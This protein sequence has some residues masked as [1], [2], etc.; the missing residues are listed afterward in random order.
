MYNFTKKKNKDTLTYGSLYLKKLFKHLSGFGLVLLM[1]VNMVNAQGSFA[2]CI[3][4]ESTEWSLPVMTLHPSYELRHDLFVDPMDDIF[5]QGKDF[6]EWGAPSPVP[7]FSSWTN[8]PMQDKSDLMNGAAVIFDNIVGTPADCSPAFGDYMDGHTYLFFAGDRLSNNGT[9]YI[10]FWFLIDGSKAIDDGSDQYFSPNHYT[11]FGELRDPSDP[12]KGTWG[13]DDCVGDLLLL[14]NFDSGGRNA[15]VTVYKWVGQGNGTVGGNKQSL[16]PFYPIGINA[17]VGK[18]N[19][20]FVAVPPNFKVPDDQLMVD[21]TDGV[22]GDDDGIDNPVKV[23]DY[24]EFYEGV[25]DLTPIFQLEG[26]EKIICS[27]TWMLETRSSDELT[28]DSKDFIGG[29]FNL[30]PSIRASGETV[31]TGATGTLTAELYRPD[32]PDTPQ[33]EE[34][35]LPN[36]GYTFHWYTAADWND[37]NDANNNDIGDGTNQLDVTDG[38][39][40]YV[41]ATSDEECD[42]N[43]SGLASLSFYPDPMV[44]ANNDGPYCLGDMISLTATFTAGGSSTSAMSWSWTGPDG[45]TSNMEDPTAFAA[46]AA[47]AGEYTVEVTDNNGCKNTAKTTVVVNPDPMVSANNDGPYCLGDMISLTATFTAGGSS[48]SAMSWSWTG[49][50]GFT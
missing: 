26:N 37:G 44:S 36:T 21:L 9:G 20:G 40:Y 31:C 33:N 3:D 18:N 4:G 7:E 50:D 24:N 19:D 15:L 11:N 8:S 12:S 14:A 43:G 45:F 38:L 34:M 42:A 1:S 48:T 17:Q 46:T 23:Y 5:T 6:K 27:A 28:A 22:N 29:N 13:L 35:V 41:I 16:R 25:I 30:S 47:K 10:G 2:P 32:N 49:P 39:T